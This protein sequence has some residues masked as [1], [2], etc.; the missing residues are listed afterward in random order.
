ML[1]YHGL[2]SGKTQTSIVIGEAFKFLKTDNNIIPG[3]QETRVFI[4]VPAALQDQYYAEIVGRYESGMIQ[5]ASSEIWISGNRQYYSRKVVRQALVKNYNDILALQR[6]KVELESKG[7]DSSRIQSVIDEID[8]LIVAN[9]QLRM[10]E[11]TK[12]NSVYKI[13]SHESFLNLLFKIEDKQYLEQ[14]SLQILKNPNGLLIIDEVQNLI[15][16]TGTNYRRLLYALT[17]YAHPLFRTVLLTGTPIYDKPYEFGLLMNLLRP[18]VMFPDGRDD[19]NEVFLPDKA[20]FIN[21]EFFKKMCSGYVSY[22]KGGNPIAYPY[23]KTTVFH[24]T[25]EEYQYEVYSDALV[26]EVKQDQISNLPEEEFFINAKEDRVSSGI[27]TNSNQICNIA[28]PPVTKS[29]KSVLKDNIAEFVKILGVE[30]KKYTSL[31]PDPAKNEILAKVK[32]YSSKF[33][34]VA[35]LILGCEGTAFVFSNYVY[36]GVDAMGI[37][38]DNIGYAQFPKQGPKGSYFIW[39][40]ETNSKHKD[41]VI[42]AKR[43][44]ND[45]LNINGALLKVMFGTQTVMEGVDFKNVNQIHILDPWWNDSRLQQIIARGIR[46]CSHKNL[47]PERRIVSVFIHLSTLGTYQTY[48][49]LKI[50]DANGN[51]RKIRSLMQKENPEEKNPGLWVF[52]EAYITTPDSEKSVDIKTSSKIFFG[53]QIVVEDETDEI[54][55]KGPDPYLIAEFEGINWKGLATRSVQEYMYS[56]SLQKL[57]VNRQ[58]E[59]VIKDV[60]IDCQLNKNGNIVRLQEMYIPNPYIDGTWMLKYENYSTGENFSR[61]GVHSAYDKSL[62]ENIFT[63]E[64]ILNNTALKSTSFEF[65]N[66]KTDEVRK[67]NKSLIV[68]EN[69]KCETVDY[70]FKFPEQIVNITINKELNQYLWKMKKNDILRFFNKVRFDKKYRESSIVD[71]MLPVKLKKFMSKKVSAEREKYINALKDFGFS[72]DDDLWDLYTVEQLKVLYKQ[73]VK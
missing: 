10:D 68:P 7:A 37:I 19:F 31:N 55:K 50:R 67:I 45:P 2:G 47:P 69:I 60:A 38:M 41:L 15:S 33:A 66:M 35:E 21:Q 48:Y 56:R 18:R 9:K 58:F 44:F 70:T 61:I 46:L 36:F 16:A 43:A 12:I 22:F 3:R 13:I 11:D 40:G 52:K 29:G 24:H 20:T 49:N 53:H 71:P 62:G 32:V 8:R 65:K 5:S 27:F 23:K 64:D 26:K 25:M 42:A 4:V 28:F 34:K 59:Q 30:R 72:G 51:I 39:K 57:G 63:L 6:E 54:I 73:I 14:D 1:I 17:Y